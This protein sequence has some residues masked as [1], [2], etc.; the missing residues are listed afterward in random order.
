[1]NDNRNGNMNNIKNGNINNIRNDNINNIRNGNINNIR[2]DNMNGK[3]V[4]QT[5]NNL[6]SD[7][8]MNLLDYDYSYQNRSSTNDSMKSH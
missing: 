8:I 6:I 1:M 2:N 5:F 4:N 3:E 7:Q